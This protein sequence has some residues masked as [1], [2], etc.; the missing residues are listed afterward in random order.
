MRDGSGGGGAGTTLDPMGRDALEPPRG[1]PTS[2]V[3]AV[4]A[5]WLPVKEVVE[6]TLRWKRERPGKRPSLELVQISA[7][8]S[9]PFGL[10]GLTGLQDPLHLRSEFGLRTNVSALK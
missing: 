10:S 1:I 8:G 6:T 5:V 3:V 7:R 9:E 2:G 4:G